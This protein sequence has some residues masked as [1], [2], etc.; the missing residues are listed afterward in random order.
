MPAK[1][2]ETEELGSNA[3]AVIARA[4][5]STVLLP[6]GQPAWA[7][8]FGLS[9]AISLAVGG[10]AV[11]GSNRCVLLRDIHSVQLGSWSEG[12]KRVSRAMQTKPLQ[13]KPVCP[14]H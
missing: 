9:L 1:A 12:R 2:L 5:P 7:L 4:M 10:S 8:P 13:W 11:K 14:A 3:R 6:W